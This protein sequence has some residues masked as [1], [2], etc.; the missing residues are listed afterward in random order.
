[1]FGSV[2]IGNM[3]RLSIE[4]NKSLGSLPEGSSLQLSLRQERARLLRRPRVRGQN[5]QQSFREPECRS[6]A[7]SGASLSYSA[8]TSTWER[9]VKRRE[10]PLSNAH[11]DVPTARGPD[12]RSESTCRIRCE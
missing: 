8:L 2:P 1:M 5:W 4:P 7:L 12:H 3:P 11:H 6:H 10:P 9:R